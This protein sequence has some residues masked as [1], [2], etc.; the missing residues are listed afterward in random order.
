MD[1]KEE[2]LK[3]LCRQYADKMIAGEK[4]SE[5]DMLI[6]DLSS[7][8]IEDQDRAYYFCAGYQEAYQKHISISREHLE[9]IRKL[10]GDNAIMARMLFGGAVMSLILVAVLIF[11]V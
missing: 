2:C 7:M 4:L 10:Q 11:I 8:D 3:S 6:Q 5:D 1:L 9:I